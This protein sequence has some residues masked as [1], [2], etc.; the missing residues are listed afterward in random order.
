MRA[1]EELV[2]VMITIPPLL[3]LAGVFVREIMEACDVRYYYRVC[4]R[5]LHDPDLLKALLE[6]KAQSRNSHKTESA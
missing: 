1:F 2:F 3:F 6:E 5:I 4:S